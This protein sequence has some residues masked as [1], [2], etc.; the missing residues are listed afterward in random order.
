M[1]NMSVKKLSIKNFGPINEAEIDISPLTVFVGKNSCGKSFLSMLINCLSNPFDEINSNYNSQM[2]PI[3]SYNFLIENNEELF[4]EFENELKKYLESKPSFSNDA[5]KF[6][7]IKFDSLIYEGFGKC[8][9]KLIENKLKNNWKTSLN[10]LNGMNIHPF[11][12]SFNGNVFKNEFDN[13]VNFNCFKNSVSELGIVNEINV[14]VVNISCEDELRINLNFK[15]WNKL[16][17]DKDVSL[18]QVIYILYIDKLISALKYNTVYVP[19]GGEIFKDFNNFMSKEIKGIS[20]SPNIQ[21]EFI[22][23]LLE[24]NNVLKGLFS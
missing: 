7:K 17:G 12:I 11:E 21:K 2:F 22:L 8:Y 5:F 16:Y 6:P 1:D 13:L 3:H 15:L 10:N 19:A 23:N 14:R 24:M 18:A 20:E 9:T 4:L